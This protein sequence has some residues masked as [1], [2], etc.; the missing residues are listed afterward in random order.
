MKY[1]LI[2]IS[3]YA[4]N[5]NGP[6]QGIQIHHLHQPLGQSLQEEAEETQ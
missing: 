3:K 6:D 1:N 2:I 5:L 4:E